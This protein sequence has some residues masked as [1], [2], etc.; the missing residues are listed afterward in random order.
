MNILQRCTN[1]RTPFSVLES[2]IV[3]ALPEMKANGH[4]YHN[5][6]CPSC[7]RPNKISLAQ[8]ERAMPRGGDAGKK[9]T[10]APKAD[11]RPKAAATKTKTSTPKPKAPASKPKSPVSKPKTSTSKPKKKS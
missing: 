10:P 9:N 5:A 4:K 3:A 6:M 11:A 8:M 2:E 1:C 7:G